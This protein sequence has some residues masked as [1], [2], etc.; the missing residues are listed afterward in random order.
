MAAGF[1][2]IACKEG[3]RHKHMDV[4]AFPVAALFNSCYILETAGMKCTYTCS[5]DANGGLSE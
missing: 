2:D 5:S 3:V 1:K 4:H